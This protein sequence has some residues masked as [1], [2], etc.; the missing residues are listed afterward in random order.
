MGENKWLQNELDWR[1]TSEE[2]KEVALRWL[3]CSNFTNIFLRLFKAF[4]ATWYIYWVW[5]AVL[6]ELVEGKSSRV[7]G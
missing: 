2:G 4:R 1:G 5:S 3:W 6:D 7:R